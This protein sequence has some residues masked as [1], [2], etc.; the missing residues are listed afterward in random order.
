MRLA[1]LLLTLGAAACGVPTGPGNETGVGAPA[2]TT[3]VES[4]DDGPGQTAMPEADKASPENRFIS[5]PGHPR[6]PKNRE[7]D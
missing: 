2:P 5:C 1:V 7:G 3:A 6:C 4:G